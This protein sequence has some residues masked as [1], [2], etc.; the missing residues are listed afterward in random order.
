[1]LSLVSKEDQKIL[2]LAIL[3]GMN[4]VELAQ[5]L[6]TNP[7]AAR[8]RL[9]RALGRLQVAWQKQQSKAWEQEKA[10]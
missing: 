6:G 10:Q 1:M 8:V 5:A 4:G 2:R 9:H 3:V 7:G